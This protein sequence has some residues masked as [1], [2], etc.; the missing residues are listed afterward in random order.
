MSESKIYQKIKIKKLADS[1]VSIEGEA[2]EDFFNQCFEETIERFRREFEAPGFRKGHVPEN[3]FLARVNQGHL[4][5]EAAE[6]TL[7]KAY[8]EIIRDHDLQPLTP[9]NISITKLA[10]KNPMGFTAEIIVRPEAK[11]PD[12]KK[13]ATRSFGGDIPPEL[14]DEEVESFIKQILEMESKIRNRDVKESEGNTTPVE[15]TDELVKKLGPFENVSDFKSKIREDMLSQ[16]KTEAAR[17]KREKFAKNLIAASTLVLPKEILED[18][19][20]SSFARIDGDLKDANLT[21]DEY[22]KKL[23]KTAEEFRK[24]KEQQ[25]EDQMKLRFL[26]EDIALAEKIEAP[27]DEVEEEVARLKKSHPQA[28][29][30]QLHS[31]VELLIRNEKVLK[32]LESLP[33]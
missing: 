30:D 14:K 18:E 19:V 3:I 21:L 32:L 31:Y 13:I 1:R 28:T 10:P 11:L 27:E 22:A 16:K 5:E 12:Y 8:P 17:D 23:N 15:L 2:T 4:L 26:L 7:R 6:T 20:A 25:I 29:L 33:Q 24:E 9:P